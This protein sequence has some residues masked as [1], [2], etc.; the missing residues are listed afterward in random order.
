MKHSKHGM[1]KLFNVETPY[2]NCTIAVCILN[3]SSIYN[4]HIV[5]KEL[6]PLAKE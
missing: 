2:I 6:W 3:A 1:D 5:F 4:S